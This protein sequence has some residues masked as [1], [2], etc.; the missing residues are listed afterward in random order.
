MH[1]EGHRRRA[2][3]GRPRHRRRP[4]DDLRADARHVG[5]EHQQPG[6]GGRRVGRHGTRH[7]PQGL[8]RHA[9]AGPRSGCAATGQRH[10]EDR[11]DQPAG[12]PARRA[13]RAEK[14]FR[15][16]IEERRHPPAA[17]LV[18]LSHRRTDAGQRRGDPQR[19]RHRQPRRHPDRG[20][21]HPRRARRADPRIPRPPGHFHHRAE[22]PTRRPDPGDR[23]EQRTADRVRQPQGHPG[24][25]ADRA[26]AADPAFRRHPRT[27]RR[28][29]RIAGPIQRRG[30]PGAHRRPGQ[31][32]PQPAVAAT[33]V[34]PARPG[35]PVRGR[36]VEAGADGPV[37]HRR[38]RAGDPRRLRQRL[39]RP[40]P[41]AVHHRQHHAHRHRPVR[42]AARARAVLGGATP[43]R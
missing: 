16:T 21:Q 11:P 29:H 5:A 31:P 12:H 18:G 34:A 37:Q 42:R 22:Q 19:R 23:F 3:A 28:R 43:P 41:D 20:A 26:A 4:H 17:E 35:R 24:S 25:G 27:F 32:L 7:Y 40:R 9:E 33:A 6:P 15:A 38:R 39:G 8:G 10:R 36:R 13:G 14:P 2:A 1:L 30:R